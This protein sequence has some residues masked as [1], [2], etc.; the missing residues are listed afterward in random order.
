M[1]QQSIN[2]TIL[3]QK[4]PQ[5]VFIPRS[6]SIERPLCA[7][8]SK[9]GTFNT[10]TAKRTPVICET[11]IKSLSSVW[12]PLYS[13]TPKTVEPLFRGSSWIGSGSVTSAPPT[14]LSMR[15]R[16]V[17]AR[18]ARCASRRPPSWDG[19]HRGPVFMCGS[20]TLCVVLIL[21]VC[22]TIK[23]SYSL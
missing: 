9:V 7:S 15:A 23:H 14:R 4:Y 16:Y 19:I 18:S 17:D 10:N 2:D 13:I 1:N 21:F 12:V 20:F 22:Q 3:L 6:S 8:H 11:S 5:I